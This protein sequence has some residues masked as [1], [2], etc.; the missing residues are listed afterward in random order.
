[1]NRG[2][3]GEGKEGEGRGGGWV[4]PLFGV[5]DEMG[6]RC[7]VFVLCLSIKDKLEVTSRAH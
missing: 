7:L 2:G 3:E 5:V 6:L 1:M 4:T